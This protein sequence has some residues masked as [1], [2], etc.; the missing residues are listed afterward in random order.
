MPESDVA[1][2]AKTPLRDLKIDACDISEV[3]VVAEADRKLRSAYPARPKVAAA[4][5]N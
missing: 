3:L 4:G 1:E 2:V 5:K